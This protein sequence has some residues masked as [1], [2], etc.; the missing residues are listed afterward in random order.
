MD[1]RL[2]RRGE[3]LSVCVLVKERSGEVEIS[4]ERECV[5]VCVRACTLCCGLDRERFASSMCAPTAAVI[6][7]LPAFPTL[8]LSPSL[9]LFLPFCLSVC[10][11][12]LVYAPRKRGKTWR[13]STP[14][15]QK[16]TTGSTAVSRAL[17][18]LFCSCR[19][20]FLPF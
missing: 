7:S 2:A 10:V 11:L 14:I 6:N 12:F 18:A 4:R 8:S 17:H 19:C 3:G 9:P 15:S 13:T 16:H 20:A 1:G 5:C